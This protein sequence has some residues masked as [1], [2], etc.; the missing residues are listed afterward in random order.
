MLLMQFNAASLRV[1]LPLMQKVRGI[2]GPPL[3]MDQQLRWSLQ[4]KGVHAVY[5]LRYDHATIQFHSINT[6]VHITALWR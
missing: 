3:S 4:L 1:P 2:H 5:F 6:F